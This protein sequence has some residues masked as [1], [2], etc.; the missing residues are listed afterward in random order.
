MTSVG[1][2]PAS[3]REDELHALRLALEDQF[4]WHTRRLA[5]LTVDRRTAVH[6]GLD[7]DTLAIS[8]ET[9]RQ[10][11]ADVVQALRRI[12]NGTYGLCEQCRHPIPIERLEILPHARLCM[13]CQQQ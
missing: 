13:P 11:L 6:D 2:S 10:G 9:A 7:P 4:D 12:A 5:R 1:N 8:I 3:A